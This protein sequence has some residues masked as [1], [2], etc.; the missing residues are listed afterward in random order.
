[1]ASH[2]DS[3][4]G[5][6]RTLGLASCS[7]VSNPRGKVATSG[8]RLHGSC[9]GHFHPHRLGRYWVARGRTVLA[10]SRNAR[11]GGDQGTSLLPQGTLSMSPTAQRV[12]VLLVGD[13][14]ITVV[15]L[16]VSFP[17]RP[18]GWLGWLALP[19]VGVRSLLPLGVV[20][21]AILSPRIL[22]R[23]PRQAH[24]TVLRSNH[25]F[26]G[27]AEKLRFSVPSALRA[28]AAPQAI[29]SAS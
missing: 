6:H 22:V 10:F 4:V 26:E 1:M 11:E 2:R 13:S 27:T 12:G 7:F 8:S 5:H 24:Q 14:A 17:A 3:S 20:G 18:Q 25:R 23:W 15:G 16:F 28:P 29:R 9:L 21:T 19:L